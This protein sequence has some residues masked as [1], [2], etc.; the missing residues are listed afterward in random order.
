MYSTAPAEWAREREREREKEREGEKEKREESE[1]ERGREPKE[2]CKRERERERER[3]MLAGWIL[4]RNKT[5][6]THTETYTQTHRYILRRSWCNGYH[7][8]K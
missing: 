1:R 8:R 3:D 4:K 6:C 7:R 2:I 5:I